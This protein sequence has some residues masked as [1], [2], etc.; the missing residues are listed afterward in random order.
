MEVPHSTKD[1]LSETALS[2]RTFLRSSLAASAGLTGILLT[3]TP[4][5]FAQERE[6]KLL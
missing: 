3:K 6:L 5:A 1:G 2:R 4:P